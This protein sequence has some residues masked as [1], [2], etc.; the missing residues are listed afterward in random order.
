MLFVTSSKT[1]RERKKCVVH[2]L[3]SVSSSLMLVFIK[4]VFLTN[5]PCKLHSRHQCLLTY[6]SLLNHAEHHSTTATEVKVEY[7]STNLSVWLLIWENV[8]WSDY[9][10]CT[11]IQ[12]NTNWNIYFDKWFTKV[13]AELRFEWLFSQKLLDLRSISDLHCF[14]YVLESLSNRSCVYIDQ[15]HN[16]DQ[17]VLNLL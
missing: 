16:R 3:Q 5:T 4:R 14:E 13:R 12:S 1:I 7:C 2:D 15:I 6:I 9:I 10:L 11:Y 17:N 8:C